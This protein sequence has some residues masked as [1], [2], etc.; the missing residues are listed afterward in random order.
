MTWNS[1]R[2]GSKK[3]R[4]ERGQSLVEL[5]VSFTLLVLLL[6]IAVD[7]GR[8]YYSY[9][10]VREAAE[11][12]ALH[13]SLSPE[14]TA[15]IEA[16]VRTSSTE[17]VDLGDETLVTVSSTVIGPACAGNSVRVTV[18]YTF[19]LTMPLLA[20]ILGTDQIPL[21]A[22]STSTILRPEC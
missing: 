13:G 16:R 19:T 14:D 21:T 4:R 7:L 18:S 20:P 9:V 12:G 6:S 1:F 15:G 10:A 17:P 3:H 2:T 22:E 5:A 8:A 11:E